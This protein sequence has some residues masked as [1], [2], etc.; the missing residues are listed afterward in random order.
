MI[1]VLQVIDKLS[2]DG[3]GIHGIARLL[4]WW[5]TRADPQKVS[6]RILSLRG[7]EEDAARFFEER[8]I[9]L[10]FLNLGKFDPRAIPVL[11]REASDWGA[12]VLHLH[13]YASANF[14]RVASK[15]LSL[16]NIVHEHV[17]FPSQP[18]YQVCADKLLSGITDS[19]IAV[20]PSVAEFMVEKRSVPRATLETLFLG[21]PFDE[22]EP[23]SEVEIEAARAEAGVPKNSKVIVTAGRLAPQKGLPV[24]LEAFG[25]IVGAEPSAHLV[26][27]GEG[28]SREDVQREAERMGLADRVHLVGFRK[29]VRPWIAMADVF[30]IA[31]LYEGGPLTLLEA[32]RLSRAIVSTPVGFVP[33]AIRDGENGVLVPIGDADSLGRV[34]AELLAEENKRKGLGEKALEDSDD[35]DVEVSVKKLVAFYERLTGGY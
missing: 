12:D 24:L 4:E 2:V 34:L 18:F 21:I 26:I 25:K 35:W 11:C 17:V 9:S 5:A 13:G 14:G 16:P 7:R 20:S 1:R 27:V 28:P 10:T 30:A 6:F 19:S 15:I 31:S 3:S 8:G 23:P 22:F 32:M 33:Q 29:D